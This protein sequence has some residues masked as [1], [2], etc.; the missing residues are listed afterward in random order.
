MSVAIN[1]TPAV[2]P[3]PATGSNRG[4]SKKVSVDNLDF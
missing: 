1:T 4:L 3:A 2:T